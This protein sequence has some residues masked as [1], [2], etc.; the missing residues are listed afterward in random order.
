[1]LIENNSV[2]DKFLRISSTWQEVYRDTVAS[3]Y[4]RKTALP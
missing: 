1:V 3:V 4:S 2:L